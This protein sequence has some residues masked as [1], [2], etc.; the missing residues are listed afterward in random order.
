MY[1]QQ[2]S[3][4]SFMK[5]MEEATAKFPSTGKSRCLSGDFNICLQK[6]DTCNYI[7]DFLLTLQSCYLL[8]TIDKP[9]RVHA[10]SAI[11][12]DN[13]FVNN[14][15]KVQISSNVITDVSDHF[16]Q[17]CIFTSARDKLKHKQIK[18]ATS[19]FSILIVLIQTLLRSTGIISSKHLQII[20]TSFYLHSIKLSIKL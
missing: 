19:H 11:L 8:P 1:R 3:P 6:F 15:E 2:N 13:I 17:I 10:N 16:P 18:N 4:E 9:T 20:L 14:P 5:Y 7:R 12:I